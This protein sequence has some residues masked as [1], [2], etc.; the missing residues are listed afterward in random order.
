MEITGLPQ[1]PACRSAGRPAQ[2]CSVTYS[3]LECHFSQPAAEQSRPAVS[4]A[5]THGA[6]PATQPSA[7]RTRT[8]RVLSVGRLPP[9]V[10]RLPP[11]LPPSAA[12]CP[13][14]PC[15]CPP[16][17]DHAPAAPVRPVPPTRSPSPRLSDRRPSRQDRSPAEASDGSNVVFRDLYGFC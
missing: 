12:Q 16:E 11:R 8:A 10:R 13:P 9:G 3:T 17:M 7:T 15:P 14:P 6:A 1:P 2:L 4:P 5:V